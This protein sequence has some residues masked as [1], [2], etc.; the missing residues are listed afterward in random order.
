M[1]TISKT[2]YI[3]SKFFCFYITNIPGPE[4]E[5]NAKKTDI[6]LCLF[7]H[8]AFIAKYL[9]YKNNGCSF[10][11]NAKKTDKRIHLRGDLLHAQIPLGHYPEFLFK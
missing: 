4:P 1:I 9:Q 2:R 5:K 8:I 10:E 7:W 11:E 3:V 6:F